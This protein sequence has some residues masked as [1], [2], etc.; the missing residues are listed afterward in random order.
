M[1]HTA[2]VINFRDILIIGAVC[3]LLYYAKYLEDRLKDIEN[4][5]LRK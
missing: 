2:P 5:L 3:F 1:I 4:E